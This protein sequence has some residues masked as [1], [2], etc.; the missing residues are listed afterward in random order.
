MGNLFQQ[1]GEALPLSVEA[2]RGGPFLGGGLPLGGPFPW[3]GGLPLGVGGPSFGRYSV[4]P[5]RCPLAVPSEAG[6]SAD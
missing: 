3:G 6:G 4:G 5:P 2:F 1:V